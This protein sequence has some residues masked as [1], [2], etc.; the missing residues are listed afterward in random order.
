LDV[1]L[2]TGGGS[3][4]M[5]ACS[6]GFCSVE[7]RRG[8]SIG[9]L[10]KLSQQRLAYPNPFVEVPILTHLP[11]SGERGTDQLSRNHINVLSS[12]VVIALPGGPGTR[13][14]VVLAVQYG[15]PVMAYI[16]SEGELAGLPRGVPRTND[17]D[18]VL[19]FVRRAVNRA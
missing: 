4:T 15:K 6:R 16:A 7:P 13:S 3:G 1:H 8:L 18:E 9:V 11:F 17:L 10:P 2:L 14:E 5:L 12:C 19:D